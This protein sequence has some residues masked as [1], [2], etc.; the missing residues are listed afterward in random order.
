MALS[1]CV[2]TFNFYYL[3]A[4]ATVTAAF[5]FGDLLNK[6]ISYCTQKVKVS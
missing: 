4:D 3:K 5:I 6:Q 2:L 1:V